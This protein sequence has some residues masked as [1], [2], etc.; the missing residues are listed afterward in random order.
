[1][2]LK[3]FYVEK[4]AAFR[5]AP[6]SADERKT[7]IA[8]LRRGLIPALTRLNDFAGAVDQYIELIN[9]FP[10]DEALTNEAALYA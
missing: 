1:L 3:Q 6:F 5:T 2:G 4:I 9:A 8:V 7:R 10:E